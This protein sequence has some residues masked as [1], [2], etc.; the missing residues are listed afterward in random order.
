[1][2]AGLCL[3]IAVNDLSFVTQIPIIILSIIGTSFVVGGAGAVNSFYDRDIDAIMKQ[4]E[5]Q[6]LW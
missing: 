2:V 6:T 5:R 4:Y 3:T 1:M